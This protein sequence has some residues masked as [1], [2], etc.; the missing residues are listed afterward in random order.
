MIKTK[1]LLPHRS[2]FLFELIILL[3][4]FIVMGFFSFS[5]TVQFMI[6]IFILVFYMSFGLIHHYINHDLH[7]RI[8]LE[9]VLISAI[10]LGAFM[11]LNSG[12]L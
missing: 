10:V 6:L 3:V 2:Y 4:G 12:R 11:F 5:V 9:Y 8:V 7:A 1:K